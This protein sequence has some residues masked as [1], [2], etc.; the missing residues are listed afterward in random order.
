[1]IGEALAG[2]RFGMAVAKNVMKSI[3]EVINEEETVSLPFLLS[4]FFFNLA[5]IG[6]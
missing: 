4:G 6:F 5:K 3:T 1:M 2:P